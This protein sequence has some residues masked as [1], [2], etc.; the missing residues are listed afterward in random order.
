MATSN[1]DTFPLFPP[2]QN[3]THL[4]RKAEVIIV[5][6]LRN[7]LVPGLGE[8]ETEHEI[9]QRDYFEF[10]SGKALFQKATILDKKWSNPAVFKVVGTEPLYRHYYVTMTS[11]SG[12]LGGPPLLQIDNL[13][14]TSNADVVSVSA[15]IS[16]ENRGSCH[17]VLNGRLDKYIF[18]KNPFKKG[19]SIFQ[20][21][22][23]VFVS[24]PGLNDKSYSVFAGLISTRATLT[25]LGDTLQTSVSIDCEDNLKLLSQSRTCVTP[26][27]I[28]SL[29]GGKEPQGLTKNYT[30]RLPHDI[31]TEV[32]SRAYCDLYT[33]PG[34]FEEITSIRSKAVG[35]KNLDQ[36]LRDE[37]NYLTSI[38]KL[39]QPGLYNLTSSE[40]NPFLV[41]EAGNK[42]VNPEL[43]GEPIVLS[44][45]AT[46]V[47]A[48]ITGY[49]RRRTDLHVP[50]TQVDK[51]GSAGGVG[52]ADPD[53]L[54]FIIEGTQQT[55][56]KL[57]FSSPSSI[58][59]GDWESGLGLC[60]TIADDLNFEL[61]AN[62]NGTIKF[63]PLNI[64]L[65][66]DPAVGGRRPWTE[67]LFGKAQVG[68]EYW[69]KKELMQGTPTFVDT[70]NQIY[71]IAYVASD[72]QVG[73]LP[74]SPYVGV[75]IDMIKYMKLGPRTAPVVTKLGL[76][77][78]TACN[79]YA[80]A[81][82]SRLNANASSAQI[83]Y[84]GDARLQAGNPCYVP[85]R[86]TIYYI[87]SVTHDFVAGQ[88]Y[89]TTLDLKYGRR[90]LAKLGV[91]IAL[92][93]VSGNTVIDTLQSATFPGVTDQSLIH[94]LSNNTLSVVLQRL[95]QQDTV[96]GSF[97]GF[98]VQAGRSISQ[99]IKDHKKELTFQ[100]FV[101]EPL[102]PLDYESLY[103]GLV[104]QKQLDA[105]K[106]VVR[107]FTLNG[108]IWQEAIQSASA[109]APTK[110]L[111]TRQ[112]TATN[113]LL[114][115]FG[116]AIAK[117]SP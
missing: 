18:D 48:T 111:V 61:F 107:A 79:T 57:A 64:S 106:E 69:L 41:V 115:R 29:S 37:E 34:F 78:Q 62:H 3:N 59:F 117:T 45:T 74:T 17:I 33:L 36:V 1:G 89:T 40:D 51:T 96:S 102:L 32:M 67:Q 98:D 35:N 112:T 22:D 66:A 7:F 6:R 23:Q 93:L 49:R 46:T 21:N 52:T 87:A 94:L 27:C 25:Q 56:Y 10:L 109:V 108:N 13:N 53:D 116:V 38:L 103:A 14:Q 81:Y 65:P 28:P 43:V 80:M 39:P 70:D 71:T 92:E 9:F 99:Y 50:T 95:E 63:R 114:S 85:H 30:G 12:I 83:T 101:W 97:V 105:R 20:A 5:K 76:Q 72:I 113:S 11:G 104:D 91:K 54:A 110:P 100:G 24:L 86:G 2:E 84:T 73:D 60:R 58:Y 26:S 88:S 75:A 47:P 44:T 15:T 19:E 55:P 82:L 90:P 8:T 42:A 4:Y 16:T 68:N 77:N 31:I